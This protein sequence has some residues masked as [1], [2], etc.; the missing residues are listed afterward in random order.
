MADEPPPLVS[1]AIHAHFYQPPREDP[2]TGQIPQEYGAEPYHDFNEKIHAECYKP[3][4]DLGNFDRISFNMGP[5]LLRWMAQHDMRT[6]NRIVR[7]DRHNVQ[8]YGAGNAMAQVYN[9]TILPLSSRRD[10]E[11]QIAWG[12]ADFRHRFGRSPQGM[13][14]AETAVDRE[15]LDLMAARGIH[16]TILAPWQAEAWHLDVTQPYKVQLSSGR[17][18]IVFFYE[19]DISGRLSFDTSLSTNA[20]HF[21]MWAL[22]PKFRTDKLER[23]EPQLIT[24]ATDGELYGHHQAFRDHFLSHLVNGSGERA[25]LHFTFPALWLRDY[26]P[27]ATIAIHD[28]TSWSCHHG[29]KRWGDNCDCTWGDG[30]WKRQLRGA[31]NHLAQALDTLYEEQTR[32]WVH[33]PWQLRE[34]YIRVILNQMSITELIWNHTPRKRGLAADQIERLGL[35]LESQHLRQW[36]FT[37]CGWFFEDLD[38]IEP[39]NNIAY[40]ARAILLAKMAT[41]VDLGPSFA[42]NMRAVVSQR[43]NLRGD[44]IYRQAL[45]RVT[46][47]AAP[48]GLGAP[49]GGDSAGKTS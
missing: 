4:A 5:T 15:S 20:D 23:R 42:A 39:K 36:M 10:K 45:G 40:A 47:D 22:L 8:R 26:P 29:V 13:W 11:L 32:P 44:E 24:I 48:P 18:M 41:G 35:L 28:N 49:G 17:Q 12:I 38:R 30:K 27:A 21:A 37:S 46:L 43:T 1:V 7:A 6:L 16:F 14:L 25:G 33:D 19:G 2:F 9:H 34:E 31:L 3:N